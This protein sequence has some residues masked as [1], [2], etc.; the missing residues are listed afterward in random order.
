[1]IQ[2]DELL[3]EVWPYG[4]S[5]GGQH[6]GVHNGVKV[7]HLPSNLIAVSE[8]ATSQHKNKEIAIE[9]IETALTHRY[10]RG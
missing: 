4:P 2:N 6:V 1:M 7:T 10:H 9:M 8:S 5:R 3:I